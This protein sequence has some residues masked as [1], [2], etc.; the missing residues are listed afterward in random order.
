MRRPLLVAPLALCLLATRVPA[1]IASGPG[2]PAQNYADRFQELV[3]LDPDPALVGEVRGLTLKRDVATLA[4]Q[5]GTLQ[6]FRPIGGQVMVAAFQGHGSLALTPPSVIEQERLRLVRKSPSVQE[7]FQ[8]AL[9]LF[10]DSTLAELTR[11]V[12]FRPGKNDDW[13]GPILKDCLGLLGN[14]DHHWLDPDVLRPV[15]NGE[16]TGLFYAHLSGTGSGDPLVF[17]VDPHEVEG[18]RVLI[19]RRFGGIFGDRYAEVATQFPPRGARTPAEEFSERQ[20]EARIQKYTMQIRMPQS[21]SGELNFFADANL[22]IVADSAVG[23]WVAFGIF[24]KMAIDSA[25]WSDGTPAAYFMGK[26]SP[27]LWVRLD[28]AL[29]KG[30]TRT[31]SLSYHGDLIDRF[32]DWYFLKSSIDWYPVSLAS[33]SPALFDLTFLSPEHLTLVSVGDQTDSAAAPGRLRRTRWVTPKPIRN[34]SFNVGLFDRY[35]IPASETPAVSVLWSEDMHRTLTHLLGAGQAIVLQ[36][37]NMKEQVGGDIV[38]AL[39][40]YQSVYGPAPVSH[41]AATEIPWSH[42]EAWPG[43]IG[44]SWETFQNTSSD[45]FD[46]VFRAHEVAH[47]WWGISVDFATYHDRWLSEGLSD[48]SGLWFLQTRRNDNKK[49]FDMLDRWKGD[50]MLHRDDPTPISLGHRVMTRDAPENYSAIVYEKGAWVF[51]MLRIL[52]LDLKDMKEDRFTQVMRTFYRDHAGARASTADLQAT[53]EQ[54]T[55]QKMDWFFAQWIDGT[56]IPTYKVAWRA[57]A[58]A[59]DQQVVRLRIDQE[60]VPPEFLMYV[61]V[62]VE[63]EKEQVARFRVKVT[64]ARTEITLPPLPLKPR[65]VRFNDLSAV[66]ADVKEVGW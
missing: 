10:T 21:G 62:T 60:R 58:G 33:R 31:L 23:P 5:D 25:R 34:A 13:A 6:L 29:T 44:I 40:F 48:F 22:E 27:Y 47:Q 52:L 4:L 37:K 9:F 42:G 55:G 30:E 12:T 15:L 45:G 49:Y 18:V 32:G 46:Q 8:T 43:L 2:Q 11:Q 39:R 7:P 57:D 61:L 14:P 64:G 28:R 16:H 1:Q 35:E 20:P 24:Y 41:F 63:M 53:L 56:A 51:H 66:L 54:Q 65:K 38:N 36:G 3:D 59:N 26:E 19:P 50:I 17:M